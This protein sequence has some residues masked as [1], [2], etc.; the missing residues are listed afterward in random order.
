MLTHQPPRADAGS[1][2]LPID[3]VFTISGFGVVV[4]GTLIGGSLSTGQEVEI[5]PANVRARIR[6]MQSHEQSIE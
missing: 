4:T 6:G 2:R 1:P 3:R 5:Q